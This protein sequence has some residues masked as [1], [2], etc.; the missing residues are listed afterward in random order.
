MPIQRMWNRVLVR[1]AEIRYGSGFANALFFY[2][3]PSTAVPDAVL[4]S[5]IRPPW[6]AALAHLTAMD[7][8]NAGGLQEQSLPCASRHLHI[9]VQWWECKRIVGTIVA[10]ESCPFP[11]GDKPPLGEGKSAPGREGARVQSDTTG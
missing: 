3:P 6:M 7:G 8:G 2:I 1:R 5:G 4:G 11:F 9:P 10:M